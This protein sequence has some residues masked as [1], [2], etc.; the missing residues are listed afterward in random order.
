MSGPARTPRMRKVNELLRE[1]IADE[2]HD[3]ADPRIG[4]VTI[5]GVDT[6]PDLRNARVYFSALGA[7]DEVEETR[8]A[9]QHAAPHL[10]EVMG[11]QVRIKYIPKLR[12]VVDEAVERGM[13][14][15][16][17]LRSIGPHDEEEE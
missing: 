12:F 2:L 11:R 3:L 7:A 8:K 4:F 13:R 16:E 1:V 15:E 10:Q 9:L 5:T 6:S 14:M 17:L